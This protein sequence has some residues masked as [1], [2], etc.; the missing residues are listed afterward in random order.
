MSLSVGIV[1]LPNNKMYEHI[2]T[3]WEVINK[4]AKRIMIRYYL[5]TERFRGDD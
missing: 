4:D 5:D 1:G 2:S 3:S